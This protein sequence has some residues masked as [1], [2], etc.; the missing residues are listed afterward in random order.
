VLEEEPNWTASASETSARIMM[1]GGAVILLDWQGRA[2]FLR[3][4]GLVIS[5]RS[6]IC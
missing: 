5:A 6:D 1:L 4:L 3:R 2:A